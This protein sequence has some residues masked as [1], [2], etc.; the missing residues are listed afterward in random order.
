M[1]SS[2]LRFLDHTQQRI[3]V[4]RTP[5]DE[6]SA[7]RRPDNTQH[8]QQT[9][10]HAPGGIFN[11]VLICLHGFFGHNKA[12]YPHTRLAC[13]HKTWSETVRVLVKRWSR[14]MRLG[15]LSR[16]G[17]PSYSYNPVHFLGLG[18]TSCGLPLHCPVPSGIVVTTVMW[19]LVLWGNSRDSYACSATD[20]ASIWIVSGS[21]LG[22]VNSGIVVG[23]VGTSQIGIA[24]KFEHTPSADERQQT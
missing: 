7:R 24:P 19:C 10:I 2:F 18:T 8:S 21:P 5:L 1:A 9:N 23:L 14:W 13:G 12:R 6:W 17:A 11:I 15:L 4:G 20:T 22:R 16:V 3:T